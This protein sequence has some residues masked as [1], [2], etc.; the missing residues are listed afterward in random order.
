MALQTYIERLKYVDNLIKTKATGN[1]TTLSKKLNLSR[2][3]T[4]T[5][6]KEMKDYG[7]PIEYSRKLGYYF[8]TKEGECV[9]DLFISEKADI[10]ME[11]SRNELRKINGGKTILPTFLHAG[12]IR[13][14]DGSF[15]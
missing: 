2:S 8:Y 4:V 13:M 3:H 15:V 7:F 10:K 6:L 11:L 9:S 1:L 5:F 14:R 12:F